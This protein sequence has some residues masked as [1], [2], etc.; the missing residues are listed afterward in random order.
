MS[1]LDGKVALVSGSGRGIGRQIA[2]KLASA[3]ARVVVNDLD[4]AP[5]KEKA[6]A[7][8][9]TTKKAA[10]KKA[11]AKKKATK[12]PAAKKKAAKKKSS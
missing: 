7:K 2:L 4:E 11:A 6:A 1:A 12:K 9:T 3:G 10:P 5:A 8:K